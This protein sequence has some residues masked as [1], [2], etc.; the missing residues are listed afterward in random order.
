MDFIE[1]DKWVYFDVWKCFSSDEN[2]QEQLKQLIQPIFQNYDFF[3]SLRLY[4]GVKEIVELLQND[5]Y[6]T[7]CSTP[8]RKNFGCEQAKRYTLERDYNK[9]FAEEA[10]FTRD[11]TFVRGKIII[12]DNPAI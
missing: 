9:R 6:V 2:I 4:P 7:V 1:K 11:K 3:Q 8:T 5:Y 10:I 12:D